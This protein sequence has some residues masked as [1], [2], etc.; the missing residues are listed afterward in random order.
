MIT[1]VQL[2]NH[3]VRKVHR[4]HVLTQARAVFSTSSGLKL[5]KLI[6]CTLY[7]HTTPSRNIGNVHHSNCTETAK[8]A[9]QKYS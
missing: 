7:K 9:F 8:L 5:D 6:M 1:M 4:R 2:E 3:T